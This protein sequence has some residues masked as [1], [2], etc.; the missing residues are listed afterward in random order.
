MQGGRAAILGGANAGPLELVRQSLL[1]GVL[2]RVLVRGLRTEPRE[3]AALVVGTGF[4][5]LM[6][7]VLVLLQLH[8]YY[9]S[10]MYTTPLLIAVSRL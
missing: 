9:Y 10:R 6:A 4:H 1:A 5:T 3:G 7:L 8:Y 2:R